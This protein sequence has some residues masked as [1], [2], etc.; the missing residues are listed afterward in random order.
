M[1]KSRA[2]IVCQLVGIAIATTAVAVSCF[3]F[4][5]LIRLN[6]RD[7]ADLGFTRVHEIEY[8]TLAL[9]GIAVGFLLFHAGRRLKSTP[10]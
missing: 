6:E 10:S 3:L 7:Q 1:N 5:A 4:N 9:A 2:G 8:A